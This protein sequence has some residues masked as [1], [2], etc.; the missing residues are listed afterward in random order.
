MG[1]KVHPFG[2]RIGVIKDW[3]S[4]WYAE[5]ETYADLIGEDK[6]IREIVR[7]QMGHSGISE[8]EIERLPNQV[9]VAIHTAKPGVIIGRRGAAVKDLREYLEGLTGKKFKIDVNEIEKPDLSAYLVAENITEQL[10]RRVSH[11]RAMRRAVQNAMRAGAL[12]I[13]IACGGRLS[14]AE[15]ARAEVMSEGRIPRHTLRADID[16]ARSEALTTYGR[17][18]VKVWIF[19]GEVLD[20]ELSSI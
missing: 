4:R 1:R 10:E 7:Q 9:I 18:G 15:M 2:F 12:G 6:R 14:G 11:S 20:G 8:I 5:G 17:I 16:F 3:K 19:K 13:K